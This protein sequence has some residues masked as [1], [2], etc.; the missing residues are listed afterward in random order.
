MCR[1]QHLGRGNPQTTSATPPCPNCGGTVGQASRAVRINL[2]NGR[3][4]ALEPRP[5]RQ[6]SFEPGLLEPRLGGVS[7]PSL[8]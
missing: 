2:H 6:R 7:Y 1:V 4:T 5:F 8:P 3:T